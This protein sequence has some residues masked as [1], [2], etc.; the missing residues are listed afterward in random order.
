[1][2]RVSW[3]SDTGEAEMQEIWQLLKV[4]VLEAQRQA[5]D[6]QNR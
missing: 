5:T 6:R 1:M 4:F 3:G 2:G